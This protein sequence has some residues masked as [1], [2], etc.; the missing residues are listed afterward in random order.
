M[1]GIKLRSGVSPTEA[2]V[3]EDTRME[4]HFA[5]HES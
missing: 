1:A 3:I 4:P 2:I 5:V